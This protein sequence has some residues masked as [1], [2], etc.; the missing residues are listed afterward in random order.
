MQSISEWRETNGWLA[1]YASYGNIRRVCRRLHH[2]SCYSRAV[3]AR[4]VIQHQFI[5]RYSSFPASAA[6]WCYGVRNYIL[7]SCRWN[8][9]RRFSLYYADR[10]ATFRA[11]SAINRPPRCAPSLNLATDPAV[12]FFSWLES[13]VQTNKQ[14]TNSCRI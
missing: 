9:A 13:K 6:D 4:V 3:T 11:R 8:V 2:H 1:S 12:C 10:W 5:P 7:N 14:L